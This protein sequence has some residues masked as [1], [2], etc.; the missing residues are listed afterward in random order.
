MSKAKDEVKKLG[1]LFA[2][3][4]AVGSVCAAFILYDLDFHVT[5]LAWTEQLLATSRHL[6]ATPELI[7]RV[8]FLGT[9]LLLLGGS[10][11]LL[12]TGLGILI[13]AQA[14]RE[15][16]QVRMAPERPIRG[17]AVPRTSR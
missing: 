7:T 17:D 1:T 4:G 15:A 9:G 2:A 5:L 8:R 3:I 13:G 12:A 16:K 10:T 11:V 14:M 6:L